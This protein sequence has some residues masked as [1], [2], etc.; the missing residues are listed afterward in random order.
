[1]RARRCDAIVLSVTAVRSLAVFAT[2]DDRLQGAAKILKA[3]ETFFD[4]V[5]TRGVA[6]PNR[7]IVAECRP[8]HNRD[9]CFAQQAIGK[10][11]RS[12]PELTNVHEHI[13][14]ALGFDRSHVRNF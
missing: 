10:I 6:E 3:I 2:R 8:R 7:A 13:K 5:D 12:E 11:L 1:M 4:Y 9:I 14:S